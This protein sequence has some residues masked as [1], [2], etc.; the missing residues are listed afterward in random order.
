MREPITISLENKIIKKIDNS[1]GKNEP[2]SRFIE[3]IISGYF[4][5]CDKVRSTN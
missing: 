2:R 5:R 3:D 4:D 1:K